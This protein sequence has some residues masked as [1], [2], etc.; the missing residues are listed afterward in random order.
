MN[1]IKNKMMIGNSKSRRTAGLVLSVWL[2]MI[3]SSMDQVAA[4][5]VVFYANIGDTAQLTC[6][7]GGMVCYSTYADR[8]TAFGMVTLTPSYKYQIQTGFVAI[9][10]VQATDAGF[11]TCSSRCDQVTYD[12]IA[13]YLHPTS[14]HLLFFYSFDLKNFYSILFLF[15]RALKIHFLIVYFSTFFFKANGVPIDTSQNWIAIPPNAWDDSTRQRFYV[16]VSD[17]G[18]GMIHNNTGG[19]CEYI[20]SIG[21]LLLCITLKKLNSYVFS[22]W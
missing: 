22:G 16:V 15:L 14:K 7:G 3:L 4:T 2:L 9:T 20:I 21:L 13:Y 17:E 8:T 18:S 6:S 11:Y 10:N 5:P 1:A 19:L 12:Q